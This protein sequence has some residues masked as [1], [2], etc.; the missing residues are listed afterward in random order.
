MGLWAGLEWASRWPGTL[1]NTLLPLLL[2][3]LS[4]GMLA[5]KK[6]RPGL[7]G[8]LIVW[9]FILL[10][11]LRLSPI[12]GESSMP[13]ILDIGGDP[14]KEWSV[15]F[16]A[17]ERCFSDGLAHRFSGRLLGIFFPEGFQPLD[18]QVQWNI[19]GT[20]C[21]VVPGFQYR[22]LARFRE[23][24]SWGNPTTPD[25]K[26][27]YRRKGIAYSAYLKGPEWIMPLGGHAR[28]VDAIHKWW[29]KKM[30]KYPLPPAVLGIWGALTLKDRR[31]LPQQT[32]LA[33]QRTGLS[34]IL[35]VSGLHFGMLFGGIYLLCRL[36]GLFWRPGMQLGFVRYVGLMVAAACSLSYAWIVGGGPSVIRALLCILFLSLVS[37]FSLR[38]RPFVILSAAATIFL[39]WCPEMLWDLGCRLSFF[40]VALLLAW[41]RWIKFWQRANY[42]K[43]FRGWR[44]LIKKILGVAG[45]SLLLTLGL[46]PLIRPI[47]PYLT[48]MSP[49]ANLL[50]IPV[51]TLVMVP[52]L[53]LLSLL[54]IWNLGLFLAMALARCSE[55]ILSL[56]E[57]FAYVPGGVQ[58]TGQWPPWLWVLYGCGLILLF[59]GPERLRDRQRWRWILLWI[60][61][62][63]LG[64]GPGI[65]PEAT[66]R[67]TFFDVGQ[68]ESI[69]VT[70]P[71]GR[72]LLIDG[73]GF[74][75]G[76]IDVGE[77]VL[78]PEL[79]LRRIFRLDAVL[80]TH[81]D[82][83]HLLGL[84][85]LV[86]H[87]PVT[88]FWGNDFAASNNNLQKLVK[89]LATKET[90]LRRVYSGEVI[91][92]GEVS[93]QIL[94][95]PK[96]FE[97]AQKNNDASVVLRLC[98]SGVCGLVMGDLEAH[99]ESALLKSGIDLRAHWLKLGHHGSRTS[100]SEAFL[101]RVNPEM[102]IASLGR[103]NRFGF[104][105]G[106]VLTRLTQRKI[107][108][109]S[110]D[111]HGQ[112]QLRIRD[113]EL[114]WRTFR[115]FLPI[116]SR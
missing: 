17:N 112:I 57:C 26:N 13:K 46:F 15:L 9:I 27:K 62:L 52:G 81:P 29:W 93:M 73:G 21:N 108:F 92:W 77:R 76:N 58:L 104:P 20:Q 97:V 25:I 53:L 111:R 49:L 45:A 8:I 90:R 87:L 16:E 35:V 115:D 105:H 78:L 107:L 71:D 24:Q 75:F 98:Y 79:L 31:A 18:L 88:E 80:L 34:H 103:G 63:V 56:I 84:L 48:W 2:L 43:N 83:D 10:A 4:L 95:P 70:V 82:A 101:N 51:F 59:L 1:P 55:M 33:F 114:Y 67:V 69:L 41:Q 54:E 7:R 30:T 47:F 110:T 99:G 94:W 42:K 32:Q 37:V 109:L 86:H 72:S 116:P 106:E 19:S 28:S 60:V 44:Y 6:L 102:A 50:V 91:H 66:L 12:L 85:S 3:F 38:R 5:V 65:R 14:R 36:L 68:G 39:L 113:G 40:A 22:S 89:H 11:L 64:V 61:A 96:E 74:A 23:P 100:T